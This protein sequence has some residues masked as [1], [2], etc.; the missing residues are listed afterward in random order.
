MRRIIKDMFRINTKALAIAAGLFELAMLTLA[1]DEAGFSLGLT[2]AV[3]SAIAVGLSEEFLTATKPKI[4]ANI[5]EVIGIFGGLILYALSFRGSPDAVRIYVFLGLILIAHATL[6][7]IIIRRNLES[8]RKPSTA[9]T[10]NDNDDITEQ[11]E[12]ND[13]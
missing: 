3:L 11:E 7:S 9:A 6:M 12:D 2:I 8:L 4:V 5:I 1:I 10:D 13:D